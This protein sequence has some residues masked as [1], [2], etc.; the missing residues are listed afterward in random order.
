MCL[1]FVVHLALQLIVIL[2][3]N[4]SNR[5][6]ALAYTTADGFTITIGSQHF[7]NVSA[8]GDV[9]VDCHL[10]DS[11]YSN[12]NLS[13]TAAMGMAGY[14]ITTG[15]QRTVFLTFDAALPWLPCLP[16]LLSYN[17]RLRVLFMLRALSLLVA[18][19]LLLVVPLIILFVLAYRA[20]TAGAVQSHVFEAGRCI[21]AAFSVEGGQ[22]LLLLPLLAW[23]WR[24]L[25]RQSEAE[26]RRPAGER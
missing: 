7:R 14:D 16:V 1:P 18:V 21:L 9:I 10:G 13:T 11:P 5:A 2:L 26:E 3:L 25:R 20:Y 22:A 4:A 24:S 17:R 15:C 8:S 12:L 6:D 19:S 23:L